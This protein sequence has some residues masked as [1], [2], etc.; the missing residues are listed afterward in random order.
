VISG[1][2]KK[3][4]EGNPK[5]K[6]IGKCGAEK[7]PLL[8]ARA[9]SK[10]TEN[11]R[12]NGRSPSAPPLPNPKMA[13]PTAT[14]EERERESRGEGGRKG[15]D[16]HCSGCEG[17]AAAAAAAADGVAEDRVGRGGGRGSRIPRA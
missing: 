8:G 12:T 3:A 13:K 6:P 2:I 17:T 15:T 1:E 5:A 9:S 16:L 10:A 11:E 7:A 14:T 4:G